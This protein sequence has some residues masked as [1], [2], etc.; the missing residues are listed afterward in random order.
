MNCM[1]CGKET[2]GNHVFCQ[3]CQEIMRAHPIKPG[4]P[5]QILPRP[6]R[7]VEKRTRELSDKELLQQYRKIIRWLTITVAVLCGVVCLLVVLFLLTI[8][9]KSFIDL[10][11]GLF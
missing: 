1:K 2:V 9:G 8:E 3:E 6:A 7:A 11:T 5:I 10:F 4:T